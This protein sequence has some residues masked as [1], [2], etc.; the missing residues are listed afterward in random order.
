MF[1]R[2]LL[3]LKVQVYRQSTVVVDRV[4]SFNFL[5]LVASAGQGGRNTSHHSLEPDGPPP[6]THC[7]AGTHGVNLMMVT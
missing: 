6:S 5:Q 2:R 4:G 1:Y 7:T 3:L